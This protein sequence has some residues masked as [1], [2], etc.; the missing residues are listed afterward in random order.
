MRRKKAAR[1]K[2]DTTKGNNKDQ[3]TRAFKRALEAV[4]AMRAMAPL[5]EQELR[6]YVALEEKIKAAFCGNPFLT[7]MNLRRRRKTGGVFARSLACGS[8]QR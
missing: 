1:P 6:K 2:I 7:R 3:P 8:Q 5:L 4:K